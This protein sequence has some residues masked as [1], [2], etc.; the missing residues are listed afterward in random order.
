M[1]RS[2]ALRYFAKLATL[3]ALLASPVIFSAQ[4]PAGGQ[5]AVPTG[6]FQ[7]AGTIVNKIGGHPLAGAR[8]VLADTRNRQGAQSMVTSDDGRFRFQVRAG[9]YSLN[10]EKRGFL[11]TFYKGHELFSTAIVTGAGFDTESLGLHLAPYA[12]LSGKVYDE[13]GE[14]VR[15]ATVLVYREDRRSG[16]GQIQPI[17]ESTTDDQGAYEATKLGDGTYFVSVHAKP[18]YAVHPAPSQDRA[19]PA[20]VDSSLDVAYPIT[21]YGDATEADDATP[22][23]IRGGDQVE[24]DIHLS[25]V[26]SLHLLVHVSEGG[27]SGV[28]MPLFQR[29]SF[30]GMAR[31][32]PDRVNMVAPGVFEVTGIPAGR[33]T[34]QAVGS[35]N[36]P[37]NEP[38]Q[39]DLSSNTSDLDMSSGN[40]TSSVKAKVQV[41]GETKLPASLAVAMRNSKGRVVSVGEVNPEGVAAFPN[42]SAGKYTFVAGSPTKLYS[43]K[44]ESGGG[45]TAGRKLNVPPASELQVSLTLV[46]GEVTIEGIAK[47]SG[48]P[49]SGAMVVLVPKDPESN[50]ELSR[51]DQSDQDGTFSLQQVI[52]GSY[53]VIAIENGWDLDWGK[54]AVLA[55]YIRHGQP[56]TVFSHANGSMQ[57]PGPVEVQPK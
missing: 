55:Q 11:T 7:V 44:I 50:R 17:T 20:A 42:L 13:L 8:V 31:V 6:S 33:Y 22:I 12:V 1:S 30:D 48:K 54:P 29:Q 38:N 19:L 14:P 3:L 37:V 26:P 32:E 25:P 4:T 53:T 24:A 56:I 28:A 5:S 40:P 49:F 43:V 21:Y 52:P 47:K 41:E 10:A 36:T 39:V 35:P 51:R 27:T 9:K 45:V 2:L 15:G 34:V 18:W 57:V 16:I 46:G 23:P